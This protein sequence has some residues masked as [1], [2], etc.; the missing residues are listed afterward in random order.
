MVSRVLQPCPACKRMLDV[1]G[2]AVGERVRCAC[3]SVSNVSPPASIAVRTFTCKHCGGA[4]Q[5]GALQCPYCDAGIELADRHLAGLCGKCFA[6]LSIDAHFCPG[7]GVEVRDQVVKPLSESRACPRCRAEMRTR[8]L[9]DAEVVECPAC[10]GLWL[11]PEQFASMCEHAEAGGALRRALGETPAPPLPQVESKVV[12]VPCATC[13]D[14]MVR[15]NFGGSSGILIDVCR[16]HG[17]WLDNRELE[18][19]LDFV[20]T[21][22]LAR[23]R[24]RQARAERERLAQL[25]GGAAGVDFPASRDVLDMSLGDELLGSLFSGLARIARRIERR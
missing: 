3:G 19:V 17:V 22:G 6:R 5:A 25:P 24:E 2:I 15:K 18:R 23:E 21:G 13:R 11:S 7:C 4:F 16:F 20:Q 9:D 8:K 10:G 1:A 12:Y 14:M